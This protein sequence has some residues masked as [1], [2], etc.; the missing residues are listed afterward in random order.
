MR[1]NRITETLNGSGVVL[2]DV[3]I[4]ILSCYIG[5]NSFDGIYIDGTQYPMPAK[6]L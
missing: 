5:R 3:G 2:K 6:I 1:D 4:H